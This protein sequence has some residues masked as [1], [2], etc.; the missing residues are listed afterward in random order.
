MNR[1]QVVDRV[2]WGLYLAA[3]ILCA[4]VTLYAAVVDKW[5]YVGAGAL[6][7]T[8]SSGYGLFFRIY[9]M[10]SPGRGKRRKPKGPGTEIV[11]DPVLG[12]MHRVYE[13]KAEW[14]ESMRKGRDI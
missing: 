7:W 11:L 13:S 4:Y 9:V 12:W 1:R 6:G 5:W 8:V 2:I 14:L 3:M 10:G